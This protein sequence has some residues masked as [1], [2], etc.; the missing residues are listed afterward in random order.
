MSHTIH[1]R[2]REYAG[3]YI[4]RGGGKT[5]SCTSSGRMAVEAL[6]RKLAGLHPHTLRHGGKTYTLTINDGQGPS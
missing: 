2:V 3:T 6:A 1:I 4:A 5:A